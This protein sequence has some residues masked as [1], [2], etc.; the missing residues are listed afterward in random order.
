MRIKFSIIILS[1]IVSLAGSEWQELASD[2]RLD[3]VTFAVAHNA[4]SNI[5]EGWKM[6]PQQKWCLEKQIS[7]GIR[8]F[9]LDTWRYHGKILLCHGG[10]SPL[11]ML[12][13]KGGLGARSLYDVLTMFAFWLKKN[14][15]E[16]LVIFLENRVDNDFLAATIEQV[17]AL[18]PMILRAQDW[19]PAE[20]NFR[21][22]TIGWLREHN[23]RIII[24]NE[25]KSNSRAATQ[26]DPFFFIYDYVVE[27]QWGTLDP[28]KACA[29]RKES[30][31]YQD[32]QPR[33]LYLFN[34]FKGKQNNMAEVNSYENLKKVIENCSMPGIAQG[35]KPNFIA[36]DFVNEGDYMALVN[37]Y[38][39]TD[40]GE[41]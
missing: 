39:A 29:Q 40:K 33:N 36:L 5:Q 26:E 8:G 17:S 21:W 32:R 28:R 10:C 15:Q 24:F 1:Q 11:I 22:P 2:K 23:K 25:D 9:M 20:H 19:D 16:I 38:N 12:R 30:L 37:E 13:Q 6:N 41:V 34:Y 18:Q 31:A 35:K 7:R 3:E 27:N 4:F 14:P